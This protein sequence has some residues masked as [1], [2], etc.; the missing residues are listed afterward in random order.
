MQPTKE[1]YKYEYNGKEFQEEF[2]LNWS[3]LGAR[4]LLSDIGKFIN[5]D[6]LAEKYNFQSPYAFANNN[7]VRLV[8]VDGLGVEG[9]CE[10]L[11]GFVVGMTDNIFGTNLGKRYQLKMLMNLTMD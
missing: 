3:D 10:T 7:P 5:I 2:S 1:K 4:N 11:K 8:D 9:C 6:P